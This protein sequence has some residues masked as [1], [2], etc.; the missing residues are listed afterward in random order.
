VAFVTPHLFPSRERG[1]NPAMRRFTLALVLVL[2]LVGVSVPVTAQDIYN[3]GDFATQGEA[4]AVLDADP[5]DPNGLDGDSNGIACESLPGGGAPEPVAPAPVE[6][7]PAAPAEPAAPE[8]PSAPDQAA[9][10]ASSNPGDTTSVTAPASNTNSAALSPSTGTSA[11]SNYDAWE[12]AQSVF[13]SDPTTY[14]ALDPDNDGIACP[15]LPKGGFAPAFWTDAMPKDVQEAKILRIIDGDTFEV[16]I[17]GVSNRVRIYRKPRTS[18]TAAGLRPPTSPPGHWASTMSRASSTSRR[19]RR[20][21]TAT[22][23]SW[24]TSGT[25]SMASPICSI[26]C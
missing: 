23:A 25:K 11:C 8:V 7:E 2:T 18:S 3:C 9:P 1:K 21:R 12:W 22:A 14:D 26:M 15:E 20:K 16:E 24:P 5:S 19:T 13:E 6:P 17:N 4:Q 10:E